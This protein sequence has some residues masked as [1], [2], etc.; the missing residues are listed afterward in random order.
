MSKYQNPKDEDYY[1]CPNCGEKIK[2]R[3]PCMYAP[4]H[5]DNKKRIQIID[6]WSIP[7]STGI[8]ILAHDDVTKEEIE[9]FA[10]SKVSFPFWPVHREGVLWAK[11]T[12]DD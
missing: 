1:I 5:V 7:Y 12:Y 4:R 8:Y 2:H 11:D 6:S 9:E 3:S 10:N